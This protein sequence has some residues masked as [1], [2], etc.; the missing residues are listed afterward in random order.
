MHQEL[1]KEKDRMQPVWLAAHAAHA[2]EEKQHVVTD[3]AHL[4]ALDISPIEK[5]ACAHAFWSNFEDTF[6]EFLGIAT[7]KAM[8][9]E[10]FPQ[11][12]QYVPEVAMLDQPIYE[13]ILSD[14]A[15]KQTRRHAPFVRPGSKRAA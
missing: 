6:N 14:R 4:D 9:R 3:A 13:D 12:A 15:F 1:L 11:A 2:K 8:V 7:A 10:Y 5:R